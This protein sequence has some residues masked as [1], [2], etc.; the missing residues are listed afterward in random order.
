M[1]SAVI[2]VVLLLVAFLVFT[3]M[4]QSQVA[5]PYYLQDQW[6]INFASTG[7]WA[8]VASFVLILLEAVF[9][10][11][12]TQKYQLLYK[13][14]W[15]PLFFYGMVCLLFPVQLNILPSHLAML[16]LLLSINSLF[17]AQGKE[18]TLPELFSAGFFLGMA[19]LFQNQSLLFVPTL[20]IGI[21]SFKPSRIIDYLQFLIGVLMPLYFYGILAFM[22]PSLPGLIQEDLKPLISMEWRPMGDE[23]NALMILGFTLVFLLFVF[24]RLQQNFFRNTVKVRKYQQFMLVYFLN[25]AFLVA[26][27]PQPLYQNIPFLAG[28][29][30]VYLTY[31]FLPDK[32]KVLKEFIFILM[33]GLWMNAHFGWI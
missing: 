11:V 32:R 25:A 33:L 14:T 19:G 28:P 18:K 5:E 31:Y 20:I 23:L 29:M 10:A 2:A 15:L 3:F 27:S 30:S 22:Q 24:I 8:K 7:V 6:W 17:Q 13:A 12:L 21:F 16:F 1:S 9:A 4:G 26:F